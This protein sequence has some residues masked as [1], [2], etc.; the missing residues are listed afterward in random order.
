MNSNI[1]KA[2]SDDV[3]QLIGIAPYTG[4]YSRAMRVAISVLI[5]IE[6][7]LIVLSEYGN[8]NFEKGVT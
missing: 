4:L 2:P 7:S 5:G 1:Y 6:L 3:K 8:N